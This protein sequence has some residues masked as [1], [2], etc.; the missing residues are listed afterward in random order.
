MTVSPPTLPRN[1]RTTRIICE[2]IPI[3]GVIPSVQP[4]VPTA[5]AVSNKQTPK[6][7]PSII[8]I[9]AALI[10]HSVIYREKTVVAV[11]TAEDSSLLPKHSGSSLRL[12]LDIALKNST[13]IV[14]VF[15]PPAVEPGEPP[16]S[17]KPMNTA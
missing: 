10:K 14:V 1:I 15:I 3:Y 7:S 8:Q 12:K 4:T 9:A 6:G 13:A 17:I 16:T 2:A 5:E 11:F